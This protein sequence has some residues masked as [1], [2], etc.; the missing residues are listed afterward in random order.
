[1]TSERPQRL[2]Q[3]PRFERVF[4]SVH[5]GLLRNG[6]R[7]DRLGGLAQ[8]LA[9]MIKIDQVAALLAKLLFHL[10][11]DPRRAVPD[12]VNARIHPEAGPH[13]AREKLPAGLFDAAFDHAGVDRSLTPFGLR[14]PISKP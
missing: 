5:S 7:R 13:R 4:L 11:D 9:N 1:M 8:V 12:R 10:A 6:V 2:V 14:Q 3:A